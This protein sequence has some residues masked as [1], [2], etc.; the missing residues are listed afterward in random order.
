M[1]TKAYVLFAALL[2]APGQTL[3]RPAAASLLWEG[4][5]HKRALGNL[6]QLLSRLQ[7]FTDGSS[8]VM[9][10]GGHLMAGPKILK[11]DLA[12]FLQSVDTEVSNARLEAMMSVHGELLD[13]H[14]TG[15]EQFY[16]WLL[17][18]RKRVKDLFFS[19]LGPV[20]DDLT[21]LGHKK[22]PAIGA[23]AERALS[24]DEDREQTYRDIMAA[25]ARIG[26]HASFQ[27]TFDRLRAV[28]ESDG[29]S[30]DK[31]T[32]A[33][34]RRLTSYDIAELDKDVALHETRPSQPRIAFMLPT[35]TEMR[36]AGPLIRSLV[37][38]V[39]YGLTRY[40]T[41]KVLS[42]HSSFAAER[43][44]LESFSD[45]LR[46]D[47]FVTTLV[48]EDRH[49][50]IA[51]VKSHSREI[52]WSLDL[53]LGETDLRTAFRI[54]SRQVSTALANALEKHQLDVTAGSPTAYLHLLTGQNYLRGEC[55][56]PALRR[57]RA[58]F[59]KATELEPSMAV[60]RARTAQTL[61]LEWLILGGDD[62]NLLHRAH[63]EAEAAM[64]IDPASGIGH[65]VSAMVALYR[66]DFDLSAE[67]F[68]EAE[69]LT[70]HSADLL[71]QHAD[72]LAH[73]GQTDEAWERFQQAIDINPLAPDLY[74]WA[75]ASIAYKRD[76]YQTAIDLCDQ[77]KQDE[78]ALR[79]LTVSHA[80]IGNIDTASAYANRLKEI[81]PGMTARQ[82]SLLS[83]DRD[84]QVTEKL[85]Y[86]YR[87]A[88]MA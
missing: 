44:N 39:A 27:Q 43:D 49:A 61:Q 60:A 15:D 42:P 34:H 83:P 58:E 82:L 12:T 86:A 48:F 64:Q 10:S 45:K 5:E 16:L 3:S 81:H 47:Y 26:D 32:V 65:W 38:D 6:R 63:A 56:L 66:R 8:F 70:P 67:R 85:H 31:T 57:A 13:G 75:G 52:I 41:F 22:T 2:L 55:H 69:A 4:V 1:P 87:L 51:L 59:R 14:E 76:D 78:P 84:P 71:L 24:L 7:S 28:L 19:A 29:L 37:E 80:L 17:S 40:R 21:R 54:L 18:A 9:S 23:L 68:L 73:F 77:M 33:L 35:D 30:P 88:G 11:S 25:Y 46:F 72:A 62:P 74:W 79:V 53:S 50:S 20:F 36:P